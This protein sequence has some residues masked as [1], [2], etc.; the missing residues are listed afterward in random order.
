MKTKVLTGF[1]KVRDFGTNMMRKETDVIKFTT[2]FT[3]EAD[4]PAELKH[5]AHT[6]TNK[7][8]EARWSIEFKLSKTARWFNKFGKL[9][10]K[11]TNE[12]LDKQRFEV[13]IDYKEI[14]PTEVRNRDTGMFNASGLY[15]NNIMF[16]LIESNPFEGQA[17]EDGGDEQETAP[18]APTTPEQTTPP[19]G[20]LPF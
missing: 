16:R 4:I 11:P 19:A 8:G 1:F 20:E 13:V 7:K 14:T 15:V 3:S 6:F 12:Q 9:V 17:F 2:N 5:R 10:E 18:T